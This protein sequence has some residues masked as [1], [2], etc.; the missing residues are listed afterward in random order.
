MGTGCLYI[1]QRASCPVPLAVNQ[2]WLFN[3]HCPLTPRHPWPPRFC[4]S[5]FVRQTVLWC[6]WLSPCRWVTHFFPV[7]SPVSWLKPVLCV[8]IWIVIVT[9]SEYYLPG[10]CMCYLIFPSNSVRQ[11][12]LQS[13][14]GT[15]LEMQKVR[16]RLN[17]LM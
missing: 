9:A 13:P 11:L 7:L 12:L 5:L 15:N 16:L 17:N 3:S 14:S 2:Q 1:I 10:F 8:F 4:Q 6:Q